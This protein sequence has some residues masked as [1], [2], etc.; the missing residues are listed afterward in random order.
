MRIHPSYP[1]GG[2]MFGAR[3]P[4]LIKQPSN[5]YTPMNVRQ[6]IERVN[7]QITDRTHFLP[8]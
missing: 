8:R 1:S 2:S 7:K 6:A 4:P 5:R 3:N